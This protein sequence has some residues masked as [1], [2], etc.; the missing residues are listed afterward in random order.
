MHINS[1]VRFLIE[2]YWKVIWLKD[3]YKLYKTR[4][5]G[6]KSVKFLS[7]EKKL[8]LINYFNEWIRNVDRWITSKE[9]AIISMKKI[10]MHREWYVTWVDRTDGWDKRVTHLYKWDF[11]DPWLPMCKRWWNR[12][13]SYS[14][15]RNNISAKW[16]CKICSRRADKNLNWIEL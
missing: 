4:V 15:F 8:E 3:L 6:W 5:L 10:I 13:D 9:D 1:K 12:W 2:E 16:I 14:I 11:Q 7:E